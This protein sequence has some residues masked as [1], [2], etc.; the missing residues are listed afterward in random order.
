MDVHGFSIATFDYQGA[1][2]A[3]RTP[4]KKI[5]NT[6]QQ[7]FYDPWTPI[8]CL[9]LL[10]DVSHHL[11]SARNCGLE[12]VEYGRTMNMMNIRDLLKMRFPLINSPMTGNLLG[13]P[14]STSSTANIMHVTKTSVADIAWNW[15]LIYDSKM[16]YC[17]VEVHFLTENPSCWGW[18][19]W[20]QIGM[21]LNPS[22]I[23]RPYVPPVP[24][25]RS[26]VCC[27]HSSEGSQ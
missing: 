2:T 4:K 10:F 19:L 21:C 17:C 24:Q 15:C 8:H 9:V 13:I 27:C 7:F 3:F 16:F 23:V 11:S 18:N 6:F 25:H 14:N 20:P 5:D 12:C 1:E 22:L 26:L